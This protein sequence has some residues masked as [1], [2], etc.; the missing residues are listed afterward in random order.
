MTRP[1]LTERAATRIQ[2]MMKAEPPGSMLRIAVD[3]GGC[4]GFQY[5]FEIDASKNEGDVVVEHGG[6]GVLIDEISLRY[7]AGSTIDFI[8][9]LMGQSFRIE[10]PQARSSCGC[11]ISFTI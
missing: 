2:H 11:G 4:S 9:D 10:N 5:S 6:A 3:G 1:T 7:M 8:D